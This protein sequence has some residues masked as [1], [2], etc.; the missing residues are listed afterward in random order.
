MDYSACIR[1]IR[2]LADG[3]QSFVAELDRVAEFD[4][5]TYA[6]FLTSNK[7]LDWVAPTFDREAVRRRFPDEFLA[8]VEAHRED[9]RSKD[10]IL[11][12]QSQEIRVAF[13]RRSI[14]FLY[15]KGL[16]YGVR[17]YGGIGRRWQRD[18]DILVRPDQREGADQTIRELGYEYQDG[19]VSDTAVRQGFLRGWADIDLHWNLRRRARRHVDPDDLWE[20]PARFLLDGQGFLTLSDE[21]VLT[22]ALLTMVGDLRRGACQARHFLDLYLMLRT[23][24]SGIAWDAFFRRRKPQSLLKPCVN[25][26]ALLL[27]VWRVAPEFPHLAQAIERRRRL[28]EVGGEQEALQL[29]QRPRGHAANRLWFQR[30]YPFDKFGEWTRRLSVDLPHTLARLNPSRAFVLPSDDQP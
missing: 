28:V 4:A 12:A 11:L 3:E 5:T 15:L 6:G 9:R 29:V 16:S 14:P 17:F 30:A 27:A 26:L 19:K 7:L 13:E 20:A 21:Y 10:A 25:V 22:F 23:L 1:T 24:E 18:V 2:A 8:L